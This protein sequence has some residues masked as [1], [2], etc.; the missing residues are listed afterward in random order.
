MKITRKISIET[1]GDAET[2]YLRL[3]SVA[4]NQISK[5][6]PTSK[7]IK[8]L[9]GVQRMYELLQ[10]DPFYGENAQ[11]HLI[12]EYYKDR[13]DIRNVRIA[14]LPLFWRMV[15]TIAGNEAEIRIFVLDIFS[16]D[17]YNKRFGFKKR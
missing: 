5:G 9:N 10:Q 8:I 4:E 12:P 2:S 7:E 17:D 14:D 13:Y 1:I 11:K 15:Y 3:K 6:M 16:H